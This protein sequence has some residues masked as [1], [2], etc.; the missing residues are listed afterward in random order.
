MILPLFIIFLLALSIRLYPLAY[1]PY[2]YNIDGL[3]EAMLSDG[4]YRTGSLTT[5]PDVGYSDSYIVKMPLMDVLVATISSFVGTEPLLLIQSLIAVIGAISCVV[6]AIV[7]H[8]MTGSRRISVMSGMF[9]ALLGTYAFCTTSAWK[10]TLGLTMMVIIVGLY[11]RRSDI[12]FRLLLTA[13][14]VMMVFIHHHSAVLTFLIFT[15]AVAGEGYRAV[16]SRQWRWSNS[17]EVITAVSL[18][19]IALAF[20]S[21]ID[22]PYYHFLRPDTD[23]YL[24]IAVACAMALLMFASM[25]GRWSGAKHHYLKFFIPVIA[26]GLITLNYFRPLFPGI[27][28]T[29]SSVLVFVLPY[30]LLIIPMWFGSEKVPVLKQGSTSLLLATIFAPLS[31][32]LFALLRAL[33]PTSHLVIYRTFDFLDFGL[34]ALFGAGLIVIVRK[35]LRWAPVVIAYFLL[36]L[37]IT[38]P[39]AFQTEGLFGVQN[40]TYEYEVNSYNLIHSIS[41]TD[42]IDSDQRISTSIGWLYNFSCDSN[43]AYKIEAGRIIPRNH[44][45]LVETIWTLSG[46]QEFPFKSRILTESAFNEFLDEQNVLLVSGPIGNQLIAAKSPY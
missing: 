31:M 8:M 30:L 14:L 19:V 21:T 23:L 34:A 40:Y 22:L 39:I 35:M 36:L 32:I 46:A 25:A 45:L 33:D 24:F 3:G 11:L 42:K 5:P 10:E 12:R 4:I 6:A 44:W 13:A 18:W 43:L 7:M 41:T 17:V 16:E 29:E 28:G 9:L 27:P 15:F 26:A 2:P 38:T 1:S 37:V 20:Y